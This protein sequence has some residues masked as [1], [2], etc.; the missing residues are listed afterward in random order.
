MCKL[1]LLEECMFISILLKYGLIRQQVVSG[2]MTTI[3]VYDKWK[4]FIAEYELANIEI[5]ESKF[6]ILVRNMLVRMDAYFIRNGNKHHPSYLKAYTQY[7]TDHLSP[8]INTYHI[9]R[10]FLEFISIDISHSTSWNECINNNS[11]KRD[12]GQTNNVKNIPTSNTTIIINS[13][14]LST[15][16]PLL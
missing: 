6:D 7:S 3:I 9:N 10:I 1:L 2:D 14:V 15:K 11:L 12:K 8:V 16:Y 13:P 5:N 4:S